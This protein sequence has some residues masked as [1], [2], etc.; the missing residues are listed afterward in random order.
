[1]KANTLNGARLKPLAVSTMALLWLA[2]CGEDIWSETPNSAPEFTSSPLTEVK[3]QES[4]SYQAVAEDVDEDDTLTYTGSDLPSWLNLD[5]SSGLLSGTPAATDIGEY[6][7]SLKV[8][9]GILSDSQSFT[10]MVTAAGEWVLAWADEFDGTALNDTNWNI[11]TGDGSQYG[12]PGWGNNE[13]EW[14]QADNISVED[15][16]LVI[17]ARE[18]MSNGYPYTSGRMRSDGKL[19]I[20]F[21]RIEAR[22][23][24]PKGQGLWPA[25]WMLP[26]DSKYGGWASGGEV[27]IME[28]VNLTDDDQ[29]VYGTTHYGM[30]WP[31]NQS[32]ST[33]FAAPVGEDFHVYA[34]EWEKDQIR[35]Y[36]NDTHYA[37]VTA[38]HWW[39]YFYKNINE[40]YQNPDGA[41]FDQPF[42]LLLNLAVGGN[43][44]GAPD[45]MTEFPAKL[46]VD[47]VRVYRCDVDPATGA[48][49]A[50]SISNDATVYDDGA[51]YVTEYDLYKG[52]AGTLSWE[53]QGETV[54]RALQ[55][56]VG[57]DNEGAFAIAETD[58]GGEIGKVIEVMS[59]GAGN[60]V[61]NAVDGLTF[62]V[63]GVGKSNEPWKLYAGELIFDLY[64]DSS[65][66]D[67]DGSFA[68]KMDSGWPALGAWSIPLSELKMDE[69][70]TLSVPINELV[71]NP[72]EAPLNTSAVLN[73]FVGE[74]TAAAHAQVANIRLKCGHPGDEGCGIYPP[75]VEIDSQEV[76]VFDDM[77]NS[78]VWTRGIGAWDTGAGFDYFEGDSTNHVTWSMVDSGDPEH[79]TVLEVKMSENGSDGLL[80]IQSQQPVDLSAFANGE[81]RFDLKVLDYAGTSSGM[82]FKVDCVFPCSTN[83]IELGVVAD[84][85]WQSFSVPVTDLV[86][87]GLNLAGVNTGIVIFPTF[88]DQQ[89]VSFQIDNVSWVV[90]DPGEQPEGPSGDV[91]LFADA[92]A[93]GW[94]IWDCC[95]GAT[96]A[97]VDEGGDYGN[98]AE[99][100]FNTT[101]TVSG[102]LGDAG[103]DVSG[104]ANGTLEFDLKVV[105]QPNDTSG[106]WLLK[107]ESSSNQVFAELKLEDS[108]EG[109]APG[110]DV[111]QH[112]TFDLAALESAGLDLSDVKIVMIFP[113]WGTGDGAVYR[114]DN[115][116]F[117]AN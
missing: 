73:L 113:T 99:V 63:F 25:F 83:D 43:W 55:A 9:D 110:D 26:T 54:E 41:P 13:L 89:G 53:V 39:S 14:Y 23:K 108:N 1:M 19:D 80:Y 109:M 35:W 111:W 71:A 6:S 104:L 74:F 117:K 66:T 72:G 3:A 82:A 8:S 62:D 65:L 50:S 103:I 96:V 57:W 12:I 30:A 102:L 115:V 85:V 70:Q 17:T 84:G 28:T 64:I 116:V 67:A 97:I 24:P 91:V 90:G 11:E 77:V 100:T 58:L 68:V 5:S 69:W 98:V 92:A 86:G 10:V 87:R 22:I 32:A 79:G 81:L 47:Y 18:E 46:M 94:D 95:G 33:E 45:E 27:D 38:N 107:V 56:Q 34:I 114:L 59:S 101:P 20:T 76:V 31:N 15:G 42:H 75:A 2:G 61:V 16:H 36:L 29:K 78:E 106:D 93:D 88:G 37:T 21:G 60:F 51:A 44:P 7:V 52:G 40:G 48:G 105:S 49:C 4:Y 112:Y